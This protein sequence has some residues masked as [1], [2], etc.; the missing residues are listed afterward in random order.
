M[1]LNKIVIYS[2]FGIL[3]GIFLLTGTPLE[4]SG[5]EPGADN[6]LFWKEKFILQSEIMQRDFEIQVSLP[7]GYYLTEEN[8]PVLYTLDANRSFGMVS[9]IVNVLS[10]P[11]SEIPPMIVIGIGYPINS[12]EEWG[13]LR[14]YDYTPTILEQSNERWSAMLTEMTGKP[15]IEVNS[16]GAPLFLDFIEKELIPHIDNKYRSDPGDRALSGYSFGGLFSLYALFKSDNSF[17]RFF[18]GS[19]STWWDEGI[20]FREAEVSMNSKELYDTR[21]YLSGGS[22][23]NPEMI[24][25]MEKIETLL[26]NFEEQNMQIGSKIFENETHQSCAPAATVRALKFLYS[27]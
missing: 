4:V 3:T 9:D 7:P 2:F 27:D 14:H 13:A 23:E 22:L 20:I 6:I 1:N 26:K 17:K 24:E 25:G 18:A 10:F 19:P 16:G 12:L 15:G 11:V 5:Q 21:L 8:Y